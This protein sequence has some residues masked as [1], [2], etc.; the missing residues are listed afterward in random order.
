MS[1]ERDAQ[2]ISP[3]VGMSLLIVVVLLLALVTMTIVT[4]S[5]FGPPQQ[6]T[7]GSVEVDTS[8]RTAFVE[9]QSVKENTR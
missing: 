6:A 8:Q 2:G 9:M 1:R 3:V 5:G 4:A 7:L